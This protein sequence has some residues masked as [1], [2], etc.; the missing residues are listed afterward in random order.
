MAGL[1]G[2]RCL[3]ASQRL[4]HSGLCFVREILS[5]CSPHA[6]GYKSPTAA[7]W[8]SSPKPVFPL[9]FGET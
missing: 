4:G 8:A 9:S 1:G 5:T 3:Q 6:N 7:P 2:D